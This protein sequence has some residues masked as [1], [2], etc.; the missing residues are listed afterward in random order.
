MTIAIEAGPSDFED[1]A[2]PNRLQENRRL[3]H[4]EVRFLHLNVQPIE[5]AKCVTI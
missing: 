5:G 1:C 2:R 4:F 3:A